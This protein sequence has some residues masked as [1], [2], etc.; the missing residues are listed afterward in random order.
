MKDLIRKVLHESFIDG[1]PDWVKEFKVLSKEERIEFIKNNKKRIDSLL[2]MIG[3]YFES[4]FEENLMMLEIDERRVHYRNESF[5]ISI[6]LLKFYFKP[7]KSETINAE[8]FKREIYKDLS[9]LFNI[10]ISYYGTPLDVGVYE[11]TWRKV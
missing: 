8:Q 6:T 9:S 1:T 3:E 7:V 4:K 10:D 11:M 5:S 2:P